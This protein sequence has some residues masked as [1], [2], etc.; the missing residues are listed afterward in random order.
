MA[1]IIDKGSKMINISEK[2]ERIANNVKLQRK[3]LK[4]SRK[5]LSLWT[6]VSYSSLRRFEDTGD[7][8]LDGFIRIVE[9][10]GWDSAIYTLINREGNFYKK[11]DYIRLHYSNKKFYLD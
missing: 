5:E 1:D 6:G 4:I 8:S 3:R 10:L 9:F 11:L 2:K 7:I